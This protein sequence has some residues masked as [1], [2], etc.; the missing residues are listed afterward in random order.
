MSQK[1]N[2][3]RAKEGLVHRG[4][5]LIDKRDITMMDKIAED[6]KKRMICAVPGCGKTF[7]PQAGRPPFCPDCLDFLNKLAWFL[8]RI[9]IER[10]KAPSGLIVPGH[11]QFK[12][13]LGGQEVKKP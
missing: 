4:G 5:K 1:K 6:E 3:K 8:P 11:E 12:T 10:G 2:R 13:T 7:I 9:K